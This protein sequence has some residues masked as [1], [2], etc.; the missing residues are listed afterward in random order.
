MFHLPQ[1]WR[2]PDATGNT[3]QTQCPYNLPESFTSTYMIIRTVL[4]DC[5]VPWI[6]SLGFAISMTCHLYRYENKR[7]R[8]F[9][10][11]SVDTIAKKVS[12]AAICATWAFFILA[13]PF[14]VYLTVR[15]VIPKERSIITTVGYEALV[16]TLFLNSAINFFIYLLIMGRFRIE[17]K[18]L[19]KG[20][21]ALRET[22]SAPTLEIEDLS[23]V[24]V[25]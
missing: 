18:N 5:Y 20:R 10:Q 19:F 6:F 24:S 2:R 23:S 22:S 16:F 17:C 9:S 11:S 25:N 4:I 13:F 21:Y 14:S 7:T 15:M 1:F 3:L 12:I 8:R